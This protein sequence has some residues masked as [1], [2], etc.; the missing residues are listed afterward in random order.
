[1]KGRRPARYLAKDAVY[2]AC[3]TV[4]PR[5]RHVRAVLMYH[6]VGGPGGPSVELFDR[7]MRELRARMD[8]VVALRDL[9]AA[10]ERG[11]SV[12]VVTL[13]DGYA[14]TVARVRPV[15]AERGVPATFFIPSGFLGAPMP[16][17]MGEQ[18]VL[19]AEEVTALAAGGHEIG[20]HTRTHPR[21][22]QLTPD[23]ARA[24][25]ED[26]RAALGRLLG[27]P[28]TSFAY[29][30]GDHDAA[31]AALVRAAGYTLAVSVRESLLAGPLDPFA[32][33]RVLVNA[34]MGMAQFRAKLSGG[35][36]V[37]ERLRGRGATP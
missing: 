32:V 23:E 18:Q 12:A 24:E 25:I 11:G 5:V 19:T 7:Q 6:E 10:I 36:A 21:L 16:T 15:L 1:M 13:D 26:D 4:A 8:Q 20:G 17:S 34:S 28:V 37:Y 22:T 29:P 27:S 31:M 9:P 35:L 14:D 30:K 3:R 2:A 33:P